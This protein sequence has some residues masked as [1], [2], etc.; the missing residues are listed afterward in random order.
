MV[1]I[2]AAGGERMPV[3]A[4][5]N[6]ATSFISLPFILISTLTRYRATKGRGG[7]FLQAVMDWLS[8]CNY[9]SLFPVYEEVLG[10][11]LSEFS[12]NSHHRSHFV[13]VV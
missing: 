2:N 3:E 1:G 8:Y 5:I 13:A 6:E 11:I 7:E 9:L 4:K 10:K 12:T